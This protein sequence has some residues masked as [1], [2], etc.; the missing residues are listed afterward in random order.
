M[1]TQ[2][3]RRKLPG[4]PGDSPMSP[5]VASEETVVHPSG[6]DPSRPT[7]PLRARFQSIRKMTET[8]AQPLSPEDCQIQ[9]MADASPVKWHLSHTT[10][11][12]ETFVLAPHVPGFAVF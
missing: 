1:A 12:F 5:T 4:T 6:I 3:D 7:G 10:W 11:F 8:L 9:S 2:D